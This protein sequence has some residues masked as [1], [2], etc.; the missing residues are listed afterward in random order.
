MIKAWWEKLNV[1]YKIDREK[2]FYNWRGGTFSYTYLHPGVSP[3][4]LHYQMFQ[5]AVDRLASDEQRANW[6]PKINTL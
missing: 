4:F 6:M 3:M 5:I 1:M 2:Y